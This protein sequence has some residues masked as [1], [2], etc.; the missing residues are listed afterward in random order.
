V[1]RI[2]ATDQP[3]AWESCEYSP[4]E[5]QPQRHQ[6]V[7]GTT[8]VDPVPAGIGWPKFTTPTST[9]PPN[10]P[11]NESARRK[12]SWLCVIPFGATAF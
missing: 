10:S 8:L 11:A 6:G 2:T 3:T 4:L 12:S 9:A 5:I 7:A 1:L